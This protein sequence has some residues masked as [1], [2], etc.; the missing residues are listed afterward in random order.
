MAAC[1]R[2]GQTYS[3]QRGLRPLRTSPA[4]GVWDYAHSGLQGI[5]AKNAF[6]PLPCPFA[7]FSDLSKCFRMAL[8]MLGKQF[9]TVTFTSLTHSTLACR[10]KEKRGERGPKRG[11]G[12]KKEGNVNQ[13]PP[14]KKYS[15]NKAKAK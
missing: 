4:K 7:L 12:S 14:N 3:S 6:C 13:N 1:L 11:Q 9:V 5:S 10:K 8:G 2:P 15:S